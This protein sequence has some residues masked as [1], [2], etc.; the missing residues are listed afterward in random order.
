M[1]TRSPL[2]EMVDNPWDVADRSSLVPYGVCIHTTGRGVTVEATKHGLDPMV[3]ALEEYCRPDDPKNGIYTAFPHYLIGSE[4]TI[5]QIADERERARHCA[6]TPEDRLKYLTGTWRQEV[7]KQGLAAW[8]ARWPG[9]KSPSHLY[10]D[11]R[12]NDSYLGVELIPQ[13]KPG[14][15]GTLFTAAQYEAVMALVADVGSR[16]GIAVRGKRLVGHEDLSPLTRWDASGGWDPGSLRR[17]PLF[18]WARCD[19][20][21]GPPLVT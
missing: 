7:A 21:S 3:Q 11:K 10:P 8:D 14:P 4:G 20:F 12:P 16:Y 17:F 2:A 19:P 9:V 6:V 13:L 18:D 15:D 1:I 5:L